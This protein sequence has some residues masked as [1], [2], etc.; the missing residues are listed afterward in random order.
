[1]SHEMRLRTPS[2]RQSRPAVLQPVNDTSGRAT[3]PSLEAMTPDEAR[4][5]LTSLRKRLQKKMAREHAYL[6]RRSARGTHTPTDGAYAEDQEL[7]AELVDLLQYCLQ[8]LE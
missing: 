5:W 7:E 3:R 6:K 2:P 1:M 8:S 4:S